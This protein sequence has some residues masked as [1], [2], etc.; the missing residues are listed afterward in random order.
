MKYIYILVLLFVSVVTNAQQ[1]FL[2]EGFENEGNL[3]DGWTQ[4]KKPGSDAEWSISTGGALPPNGVIGE[5]ELPLG[6]NTGQYN[7]LFYKSS[8]FLHETFLVSPKFSFEFAQKPELRFWY[9]QAEDEL[10]DGGGKGN[11]SFSIYY[12]TPEE[13]NEWIFLKEYKEYKDEWTLDSITIPDSITNKKYKVMQ[14]GFLGKSSTVGFGSCLDDVLLHETDTV[15]K[16]I[17]KI[18]ASQPN[19]DIIPSGSN[20]NTIL[21]LR[22]PVQGNDG[23]LILDSL[24]VTSLYKAADVVATNGVKLYHTVD[25]VF[26]ND[27]QIGQ[28]VSFENGKAIFNNINCELPFGNSYVWITYDIPEDT[29]HKFKGLKVDAKVEI[30]NIKI[31]NSYFPLSDID[32]NGYREI[33]ESIFFDDFESAKVWN[34]VGEFEI[35]SA[36]G[37]GGVYQN[38]DPDYATSGIHILGTDITGLGDKKG[39]Y[40]FGVQSNGYVAETENFNCK[41]YKDL[42][43]Q[44]YRWLNVNFGDTA[45]IEY[46]IDNGVSWNRVWKSTSLVAEHE[47]GF[48]QM[49]LASILDRNSNVKIRFTLGPTGTS[50]YLSGWN[51]DD[52]AITGTYVN[53]DVGISKLLTPTSGCGHIAPEEVKVVI[54]NYGYDKSK[55]TIPVGYSIDNGVSWVYDTLFS[56]IPKEGTA[57]FTFKNFIDLTQPG[58]HSLLLS[59]F[60]E[61][62]E[63]SRNDMLDTILFISPNKTVP[64]TEYFDNNNGY[65]KNEGGKNIWEYGK[66]IATNINKAFSGEKCWVTNLSGNYENNDSSW[67]ESPC[68]DFSNTEKPIIDFELYA[69][70]EK[71]K[72]GLSIYYTKNNGVSWNLVPTEGSYASWNWYNNTNIEVFNHEGW[73]SIS[74]KWVHVRQI[75][76][77]DIAGSSL[78]KFRFLFMSNDTIVNEGVAID[79]IRIFDAPTDAGVVSI[80]SPVSS[81]YLNDKQKVKV[82][83][84]NYGIRRI[85]PEDTIY[86]NVDYDGGIVLSDTFNLLTPLNIN[87]TVQFQ[88]SGDINMFDKQKYGLTAYTNIPED[89]AYYEA[90]VYNDTITDT[91]TVFGEPYFSLGPDVG[92]LTP[93]NEKLIVSSD[94]IDYVW[95]N[96]YSDTTYVNDTFPVPAFPI[97]IDDIDFSVVI[98]NDSSCVAKDTIKVIRSISDL[99]VIS[100]VGVIDTCINKQTHQYLNIVIQNFSPDTIYRIGDVLEVGYQFNKDTTYIE[101]DTLK[102]ILGF[103]GVT[104]YTF[105]NPPVFPDSG[106]Y[107]L[108]VFSVIYAD[109]DYSNDTTYLPVF[110]YPLPDVNIGE[111]TI[112]TADAISEIVEFNAYSNYFKDYK[113]HDNSTDSVFIITKK[114]NLKYFVEVS[115][116]NGCGIASDT[117]QIISD[118]WVV[119]SI[120]YPLSS[121]ILSPQEKVAVVINN[122]SANTYPDKYE[123]L[124][125]ITVDDSIRMDTIILNGELSAYSDFV[126]EFIPEYDMSKIKDYKITVEIFPKLDIS[127]SDNK[128]IKDIN[129]WGVKYVDLGADTIITKRAD[130]II[131]NAGSMFDTYRWQDGTTEQTYKIEDKKSSTYWVQVTDFNNC[132]ASSDTVRIISLDLGVEEL[133]SPESQCDISGIN[134]IMFTIRNNG[135]GIIKKGQKI[136]MYYKVDNEDFKE[137]S[138]TLPFDLEQGQSKTITLTEDFNFN[139]TETYDFTLYIKTKNDFFQDNDTLRSSIYR[140]EHPS[141]TLGKDIYTTKADTIKLS[142][143]IGFTTYKWQDGSRTNSFDVE[144]NY[145][146]IYWVKVRNAYGCTDTDTLNVYTYNISISSIDS[147]ASCSVLPEY[148]PTINIKLN[149]E[150]TLNVGDK[151]DITYTFDGNTV[152][153]ELTLVDTF[154]SAAVLPYQFSTPFNLSND[155]NYT[156]DAT[157]EMENEVVVDNNN[158]T[159]NFKVGTDR[160]D[161]GKDITTYKNMVTLDAGANFI[162]YLWND[163]SILQTLDVISTGEYSVE[164][165]DVNLCKSA[166]TVNVLMLKPDYRI[167]EILGLKD[168]CIHS[169]DEQILFVLR[170]FGNDTIFKDSVINIS[171]KINTNNEV[172]ESYTF[173]NKLIPKD[174]VIINFNS[175]ANLELSGEYKLNVSTIIGNNITKDTIINTWGIPD[176]D[177]GKDIVTTD[178][179]VLLDAGAGTSYQTYL[180]STGATTQAITVTNSGEYWVKVFNDKLCVNIDTINIKFLPYFLKITQIVSPKY[181]CEKISE[182]KVTIR[183]K[184]ASSKIIPVGTDITLGYIIG[185][186]TVK[187]KV[188]FSNPIPVNQEFTYNYSKKLNLENVDSYKMEIFTK[189]EDDYMDSVNFILNIYEKPTF[190]GGQDSIKGVSFPYE[191]D[192]QI[193]QVESYL[194]STGATTEKI[195]VYNS[196]IYSLTI[197]QQDNECYFTDSIFITDAIGIDDIW[198]SEISIYPNP[199][200]KEINI[201]LPNDARKVTIQIRSLSGKVIYTEKNVS[202]ESKINISDWEQGVYIL[203]IF[204]KKHSSIHQIIKK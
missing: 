152:K 148:N 122:N 16:Y 88:L 136:D 177:L 179:S 10:P 14:L 202:K 163:N 97:G 66:P 183:L 52:F 191:I 11:N 86:V 124:A 35:D 68:F 113:W 147:V 199:V 180:W 39:D 40:E 15:T 43:L 29:E 130:T 204:N 150:D 60:V 73:D 133:V 161:L 104:N 5:D 2:Q 57:T 201:I 25:P 51:I 192:P 101:K 184:N 30:N 139:N 114:E 145:S 99:G 37:L 164:T 170:N 123:M 77:N 160:V 116:T 182:E 137:Q 79:D 146:A 100:A 38:P 185:E 71:G 102:S 198:N 109:L 181:G 42:D 31:N 36:R 132:P 190:F 13:G 85:E 175:K 47:W 187:E 93:Q 165:K 118:N 117:V 90:G 21:R 103:N 197:K 196:D 107:T 135:S 22:F 48:Q 129:V 12:R 87:D 76:P 78:V 41:Y 176:V 49:G 112:M 193:T 17:E 158:F 119:D 61:G 33:N 134:S 178:I 82:A 174:S 140:L 98:T 28:S 74:T 24:V 169:R 168:S 156:I 26:S 4:E 157:V 172:Q 69:L 23:S 106:N 44:F 171:Y 54:K 53:N 72:D 6:A 159:Q 127:K 155:G 50:Q 111:D 18:Y 94:F 141:I 62:D 105:K 151:I 63:D 45:A 20:D 142:V 143:P 131:L 149:S 188:P 121:C 83:I 81:C 144:D 189:Y 115:D 92:T 84:K 95:K 58:Y 19:Q 167:T 195:K 162:S 67:I 27:N 120:K 194:W 138:Y 153:E 9:A 128:I 56:E 55:N 8:Y 166:D 80:V 75:L 125:Q 46:S 70:S 89:T 110:I 34:L 7:A 1:I 154:T 173:T 91:V 96:H 3:P 59:T 203:H 32:P 200:D 126:Y 64:Y 108:K 65:W 186:D